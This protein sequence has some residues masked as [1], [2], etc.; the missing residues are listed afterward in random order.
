MH[1]DLKPHNVAIDPQTKKVR[2][3]DWGI[4]DVYLPNKTYTPF[5]GTKNY[6]A[7]EI[8]LHHPLYYYA[9]DMWS[10]GCIFASMV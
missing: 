2:I 3:L 10:V 6:R 1:R 4:A 7:P 8:L 9:V 5:I